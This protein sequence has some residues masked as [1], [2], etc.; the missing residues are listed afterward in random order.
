[1]IEY[2]VS[3]TPNGAIIRFTQPA[4]FAREVLGRMAEQADLTS[5]EI[6]GDVREVILHANSPTQGAISEGWV[7]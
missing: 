3:D 7:R 5:I 4:V 2:T 6:V 1:M